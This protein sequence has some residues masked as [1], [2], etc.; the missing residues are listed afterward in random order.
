MSIDL[1]SNMTS[2]IKNATLVGKSHVELPFSNECEAVLKVMKKEGYIEGVKSFK[3]K[4]KAYK[5]LRVDLAY[6]NDVSKIDE[7][8]RVSKPGNRKY[9]KSTEIGKALGGFG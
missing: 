2:A 6:E 9:K 4:G 8:Q 7:I 1:L 5:K 3:E